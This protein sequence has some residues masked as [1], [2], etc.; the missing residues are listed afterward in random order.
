MYLALYRKYRPKFFKE[1]VGQEHIVNTIKNEI[2]K[3]RISHSYIFTGTRGT[4]KTS[5]AKI[6]SKAINCLNIQLGEPCQ[7]CDI[8]RGI[9]EGS[10]YD[11]IEIDAASNNGVDNIREIK[12]ESM[13]SPSICR[14]RVY[15]ID[16]VHMLSIG[17]FNALLKI[18]EEPPKHLLFILATTNIEKVPSTILSRCQRFDFK[19]INSNEI[20]QRID[21][22]CK[23]EGIEISKKACEMI[24]KLADGGMRDALSILDQCI[25]YSSNV[26]EEDVIEGIFGISDETYINELIY[27]IFSKDVER[28]LNLVE[29]LVGSNK[30]IDIFC[31]NM[32]SVFRDL[33]IIKSNVTSKIDIKNYDKDIL[34]TI[35]TKKLSEII[36]I[37]DRLQD[38]YI[39]IQSKANKRISLEKF[40]INISIDKNDDIKYYDNVNNMYNKLQERLLILENKL[41]DNALDNNSYFCKKDE[42]SLESSQKHILNETSYKNTNHIQNDVSNNSSNISVD[43]ADIIEFENWDEIINEISEKD[44]SLYIIIKDT[45]AYIQK[46]LLFIDSNNKMFREIIKKEGNAKKLGNIIYNKTG[47]KY[48]IMLRVQGNNNYNVDS[49][50]NQAILDRISNKAKELGIDVRIK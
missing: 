19:K 43:S 22:V 20:Q 11:I 44:K 27:V 13:Y 12:D 15:I 50:K 35:K 49:A 31:E 14:Y 28:G 1:I 34:E 47:I 25:G 4:G 41:I 17:A 48:R 6:F 37:L 46:D 5:C 39:D 24:S 7:E 45:K 2:V 26:I 29:N 40:I 30:D 23:N 21:T 32:I 16:E 3:S 33:M 36:D 18:M 42:N 10:I 9:E 8:C 38:L